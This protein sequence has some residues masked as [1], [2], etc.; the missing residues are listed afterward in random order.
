MK[1]YEKILVKRRFL[2][3]LCKW[4]KKVGSRTIYKKKLVC[5]RKGQGGLRFEVLELRKFL[6]SKWLYKLINVF[7]KNY[8][9]T[10]IYTLELC[11]RSQGIYSA[12]SGG[13]LITD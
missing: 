1:F 6:L 2:S 12:D 4:K 11:Q 5:H 10:S 3:Q 7:G 8:F 9:T 13:G